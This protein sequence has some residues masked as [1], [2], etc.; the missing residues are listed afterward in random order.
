MGPDREVERC[1][2]RREHGRLLSGTGR[3]T[4]RLLV[5]HY[6]GRGVLRTQRRIRRQDR[7]G[8]DLL[9]G[10]VV[11][12]VVS[13]RRERGIVGPDREVERCIE[14][15]ELRLGL[16]GTG[17]ETRFG[18]V[19]HDS[20]RRV[21]RRVVAV[22]V[23]V[24]VRRVGLEERDRPLQL[25]QRGGVRERD[26][27]GLDLGDRQWNRRLFDTEDLPPQT[28]VVLSVVVGAA[29]HV[30]VDVHVHLRTRRGQR[31]VDVVAVD[32]RS[33]VVRADHR[34]VVGLRRRLTVG[35]ELVVVQV[36][37]GSV[38][39]SDRHR[40]TV[41][42]GR[43]QCLVE[44]VAS[45]RNLAVDQ[46]DAVEH[47]LDGG[48]RVVVARIARGHCA[49]HVERLVV[50][51]SRTDLLLRSDSRVGDDRDPCQPEGKQD[52]GHDRH[53]FGADGVHWEPPFPVSVAGAFKRSQ[54]GTVLVYY[55]PM[56]VSR[57]CKRA[58]EG[59]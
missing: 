29:G 36:V 24:R 25:C 16:D 34:A 15:R 58:A 48:I 11:E 17:G 49:R 21:L 30:L 35:R 5:E 20:C 39:A 43:R 19:H 33:V 2:E 13:D 44:R 12:E 40:Q 10:P 8:H 38:E 1:I 54:V 22:V 51:R 28:Q 57:N 6:L 31:G 50:C 23:R 55:L 3:Q 32:E 52:D 18:R 42:L 9:V 26:D 45:S 37:L 46:R 56:G 14:R 59:L 41:V 47:H 4:G 7:V 27:P 53:H